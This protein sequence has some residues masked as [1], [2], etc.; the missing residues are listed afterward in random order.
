VDAVALVGPPERCR[1]RLAEYR[2]AGVGLPIVTPRVRDGGGVA[3]VT[4]VLRA[5]A[6]A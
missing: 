1:E 6:P 4:D 2:K 5:C 3:A